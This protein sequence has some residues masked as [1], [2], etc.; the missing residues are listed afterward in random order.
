MRR[1]TPTNS[2]PDPFPEGVL[3]IDKPAGITSHDVV[4]AVRR[5]ILPM[6]VGH[7]GTLDPFA[8]G[9]LPLCIGRATRLSR[10]LSMEDKNYEGLIEMGTRTTTYDREGEVLARSE[11]PAN[12]PESVSKI[13]SR[14][15]GTIRLIPPPFSAK[16]VMGIPLYEFARADIHIKRKPVETRIYQMEALD[17]GE[18]EFRFRAEVSAGTYLRSLAD[19]LGIEV[20]CGAHLKE[21]RRTACGS[22]SLDEAT[23]LEDFLIQMQSDPPTARKRVIPMREIPLG[24][25]TLVVNAEGRS[26]IMH[27]RRFGPGGLSRTADLQQ[28]AFCRVEDR[29]GELLAIAETVPL[30][31]HRPRSLWKPILVFPLANRAARAL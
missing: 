16:K 31:G 30:P 8:T 1:N 23:G 28:G 17:F 27:G 25:H 5:H 15:Q 7:T 6:K 18:R 9:L 4:D 22:L 21:L 2:R 12:W 13:L 3:L 19:S 10:F 29:T 24:M 14:I 26:A 20:G 11:V